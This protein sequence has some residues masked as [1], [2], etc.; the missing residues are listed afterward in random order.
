M[1]EICQDL[2]FTPLKL[3]IRS[4][5]AD[6]RSK[7]KKICFILIKIISIGQT[8]LSTVMGSFFSSDEKHYKILVVSTEGMQSTNPES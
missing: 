8:S 4:Q 5:K 1:P 2:S 3:L 7:L 6:V